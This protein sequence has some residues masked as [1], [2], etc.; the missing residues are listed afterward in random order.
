MF[1]AAAG[2]F[3]CCLPACTVTQSEKHNGPFVSVMCAT[4]G[5]SAL[6]T[7]LMLQFLQGNYVLT[8]CYYH[9]CRRLMRLVS[10]AEA[11]LFQ[12]QA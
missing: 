8:F 5:A 1:S 12:E 10:G 2:R 7:V 11:V 3:P 6:P 9:R 4:D